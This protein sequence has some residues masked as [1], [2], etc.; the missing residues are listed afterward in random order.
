MRDSNLPKFLAEDVP[1]FRAILVDLFPGVNVPTD[2]YGDLL[3]AIK[4]SEGEKENR[5]FKKKKF[6]VFRVFSIFC[7]FRGFFVC[8]F[9]DHIILLIFS[10][11]SLSPCSFFLPTGGNC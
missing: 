9:P 10:F 7:V 5:F 2:D 6:C 11:S 3:V 4:V 1:L 8:F